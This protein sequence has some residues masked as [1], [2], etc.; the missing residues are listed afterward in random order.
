[1]ANVKRQKDSDE[2]TVAKSIFDEI[3]EFTEHEETPKETRARKGGQVRAAKLHKNYRATRPDEARYSPA[4]CIGSTKKVI[5]GRPDESKV[6]TSYVERHNLTI[7][8]SLR[9]F[10]R[11]TNGFSKKWENLNYMLAIFFM[12][13]NFCRGHKSLN[14]AT[15]AMA[16]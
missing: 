3:V 6:S 11:L 16:G 15:P 14:G 7:R 9:R 12:F 10:T 4:D 13:Y 2:I 5:V 8:M 1:M